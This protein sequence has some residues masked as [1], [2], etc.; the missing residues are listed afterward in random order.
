MNLNFIC[1]KLLMDED[2]LMIDFL[3]LFFVICLNCKYVDFEII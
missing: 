2:L 3:D 1:I